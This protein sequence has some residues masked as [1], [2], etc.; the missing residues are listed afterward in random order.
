MHVALAEWLCSCDLRRRSA[1]DIGE[2]HSAADALEADTIVSTGSPLVVLT[3]EHTPRAWSTRCRCC[4]WVSDQAGSLDAAVLGFAARSC[5]PL[6]TPVNPAATITGVVLRGRDVLPA[7]RRETASHP[8]SGVRLLDSDRVM[9]VDRYRF[10]FLELNARFPRTPP[11]AKPLARLVHHPAP[12]HQGLPPGDNCPT[13]AAR[14]RFW[15]DS[16]TSLDD[17]RLRDH[18]TAET[19]WTQSLDFDSSARDTNRAHTPDEAA[20]FH[21]FLATAGAER[22]ALLDAACGSGGRAP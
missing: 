15:V 20:A 2:P 14:T 6:Q 1:G 3:S 19:Y 22:A 9:I 12:L 8:W 13:T 7:A 10:A 17:P 4:A 21:A 11:P 5:S 18:P 16:P